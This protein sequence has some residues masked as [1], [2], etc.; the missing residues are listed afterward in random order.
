MKEKKLLNKLL[1]LVSLNLIQYGVMIISWWVLGA[2]I[3]N[4]HL[5]FAW[6][7]SWGLL[8]LTQ[9]PLYYFSSL[10]EGTFIIEISKLIKQKLISGTLNLDTDFLK[11]DG[12]GKLLGRVL[13]S[14]AIESAATQGGLLGLFALLEIIISVTVLF[15]GPEG[16]LHLFLLLMLG[17]YISIL[18]FNLFQERKAWTNQRLL[19]S[20]ELIEKMV[21]HRT[22]IVQQP[23]K[24]WHYNED[25]TLNNYIKMSKKMDT[26]NAN[27]ISI[28]PRLW[29]ILGFIGLTPTLLEAGSNNFEV[30]IAVGGILL[31]Y[32]ALIKVLNSY[33]SLITAYISWQRIRPLY[34]QKNCN[35]KSMAL[36]PEKTK[37]RKSHSNNNEGDI[38]LQMND[39]SFRHN[40]S[41]NN[42]LQNV[43]LT[44]RRGD[45][46]LL[47]GTSGSG[48]STFLNLLSGLTIQQTGTVLLHGYDIF[49]LGQN[50]WRKHITTSP[51]FHENY[52][53][54]ETFLFNLLMAE[55]WPPNEEKIKQ[56]YMICN[57]LGLSDVIANMPGGIMQILGET[58]WRL[59]QGEKSRLYIARALLQNPELILLD[60]NFG[61][62]DPLTLKMSMDC[63]IKH[64]NALVVVAH[65]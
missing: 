26:T 45:K 32:R 46:I 43:N 25:R 36:L 62:L 28:I 34:E 33:D 11:R 57:E 30:A 54:N 4:D 44:I 10:S 39:I 31:T 38:L 21:G 56:A 60:E 1:S 35:I 49:S 7:I 18:F 47:Q 22:R 24:N 6:I 29:L 58:G 14:Q 55:H 19:I 3:L 5:N 52:I 16:K 53:L 20:H 13:D 15:Q 8:L 61:T 17:I 65:P 12:A 2:S 64:S 48:K 23:A 59:S 63:V 41:S 42:I 51:Q 37:V 50:T 9:I 40:I 27:I